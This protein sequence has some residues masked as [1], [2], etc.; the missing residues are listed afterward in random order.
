MAMDEGVIDRL[1][2]TGGLVGYATATDGGGA[3]GNG[4]GAAA[5]DHAQVAADQGAMSD[6]RTVTD[7][8]AATESAA[9]IAVS[10]GAKGQVVGSDAQ[11]ATTATGV[12]ASADVRQ[13]AGDEGAIDEGER[14][15]PYL[16]S[17]LLSL[18][19]ESYL[20][21]GTFTQFAAEVLK[22]LAYAV[23]VPVAFTEGFLRAYLSIE[24]I[25]ETDEGQIKIIPKVDA[26][27]E[28]WIRDVDEI[29]AQVDPSAV[30]N[31]IV[32]SKLEAVHDASSKVMKYDM[33]QLSRMT[34]GQLMDVLRQMQ[35]ESEEFD[36]E[37]S[38]QGAAESDATK[39]VRAKLATIRR[40]VRQ[41][42]AQARRAEEAVERGLGEFGGEDG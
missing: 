31:P 15:D 29:T 27:E 38:D 18:I 1:R 16:K 10:S 3:G 20:H 5:H 26:S 13:S 19:E 11:A 40:N 32:R 34:D 25:E 21:S 8:T 22:V 41:F 42:Q 39:Y 17:M 2:A 12:V 7:A 28:D 24:R 30:F 36:D 14:A 35:R 4:G 37:G 33:D 9:T 6:A 23:T